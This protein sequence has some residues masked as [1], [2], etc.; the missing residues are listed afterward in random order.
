LI[1]KGVFVHVLFVPTSC[2]T[3]DNASEKYNMMRSGRLKA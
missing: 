1:Y 3:A 2:P